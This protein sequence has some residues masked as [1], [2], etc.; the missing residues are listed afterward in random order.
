MQDNAQNAT[1]A[2]PG[3]GAN[4]AYLIHLMHTTGDAGQR[5]QL[6]QQVA[7]LGK[8]KLSYFRPQ[9]IAKLIRRVAD[10]C[11]KGVAM[12]TKMQRTKLDPFLTHYIMSYRERPTE[13]YQEPRNIAVHRHVRRPTAE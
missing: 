11:K 7:E 6:Q 5:E 2:L 10:T 3:A 4:L 8:S 9:Q 12:R 13:P 1:G